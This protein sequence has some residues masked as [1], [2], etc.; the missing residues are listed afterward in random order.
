MSEHIENIV[1]CFVFLRI[2]AL[3]LML[4]NVP[5]ELMIVQNIRTPI[6][7]IY[8]RFSNAV[9]TT[10]MLPMVRQRTMIFNY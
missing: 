5:I 10:A 8:N 1:N 7:S 3:V 4:M 9:A 6:V 2:H